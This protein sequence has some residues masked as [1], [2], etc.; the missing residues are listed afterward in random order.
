MPDG[1]AGKRVRCPGCRTR[2]AVPENAVNVNPYASPRETPDGDGAFANE[3][4]KPVA[5]KPV[6]IKPLSIDEILQATWSSF[7]QRPLAASGFAALLLLLQ[8]V[9]T[10]IVV[11]LEM[12][13]GGINDPLQTVGFQ[14]VSNAVSLLIGAWLQVA[15]TVYGLELTRTG[16]SRFSALATKPGHYVGTLALQFC[17]FVIGVGCALLPFGILAAWCWNSQR[18]GLAIV[19]GAL[20]AI[21]GSVAAAIFYY[22]TY[23]TIA[24]LV[25]TKLG[26]GDAVR[27]STRRM[28]GTKAPAFCVEI[29]SGAVGTVLCIVTLGLATPTVVAFFGLLRPVIYVHMTRQRPLLRQR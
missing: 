19:F 20:A 25:D 1:A 3:S 6:S 27:E 14:V 17:T 18:I 11:A 24:L 2:L 4:I 21:A 28:Q 29:I 26:F 9:S 10:G 7:R 16:R 13:F 12:G 23:L 22:R 8:L 15:V 5:P